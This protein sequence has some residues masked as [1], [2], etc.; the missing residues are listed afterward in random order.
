MS[1]VRFCPLAFE[2]PVPPKNS[3]FKQSAL[4]GRSYGFHVIISL[5]KSNAYGSAIGITF[6]KLC[7]TSSLLAR[8]GAPGRF[9]RPILS[10]IS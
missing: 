4:E 3:C 10:A 6:Y 2:K 7:N 5:I 9:V 8:T 1:F